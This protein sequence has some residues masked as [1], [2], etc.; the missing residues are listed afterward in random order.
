[1]SWVLRTIPTAPGHVC[2]PSMREVWVTLPGMPPGS[3]GEPV[4]KPRRHRRQALAGW[5]RL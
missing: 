3:R 4:G 2:R 1:M 5:Q